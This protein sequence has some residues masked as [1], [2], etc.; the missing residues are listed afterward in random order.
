MQWIYITFALIG[1]TIMVCQFVMTVLGVIDL[2][3]PDD[4]DVDLDTDIDV[5]VD[6]PEGGSHGSDWLFGIISFR[7]LVAAFAFSGLGGL[8]GQT[9]GWREP[10]PLMVA[11]L[12]GYAAMYG[13]YKMMRMIARLNADGTQRIEQAV[14]LVGT[15]YVSIPP[16]DSGVGKIH[17]K[18]Q[19]RTVE[20]EAVSREAES[21][22]PGANIVVT[23]VVGHHRV[24]VAPAYEAAEV[25]TPGD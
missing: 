12:L 8:L 18:L 9:F 17:L 14:G 1:G 23:D 4:L 16:E 21:L 19:N 22:K 5:D 25:E 20:F 11:L 10:G 13:S 15:V 7:T 3:L 6:S 2:D 24:E